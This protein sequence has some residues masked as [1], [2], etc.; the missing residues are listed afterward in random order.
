MSFFPVSPEDFDGTF[1]VL[2]FSPCDTRQCVDV[3]IEDDCNME[4]DEYF[5]AL[6][7]MEY[8]LDRIY[9]NRGPLVINITDSDSENI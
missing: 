3:Y 5:T 7:E 2:T 1:A 8:F 9:I 4:E 6:L